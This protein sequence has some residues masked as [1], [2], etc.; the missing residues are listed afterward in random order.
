MNVPLIVDSNWPSNL[1]GGALAGIGFNLT[2]SLRSKAFGGLGGA[3]IMVA[4]G[5]AVD[6]INTST[7]PNT[8]R[9]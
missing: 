6:F 5:L 3:V 9:R 2:N 7:S 4:I 1:L 8:Y